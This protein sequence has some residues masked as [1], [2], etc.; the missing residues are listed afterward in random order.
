MDLDGLDYEDICEFGNSEPSFLYHI[1]AMWDSQ[2]L[3]EF[4][5]TQPCVMRAGPASLI[6]DPF[7][8]GKMCDEFNVLMPSG[9]VVELPAL[10]DN[11]EPDYFNCK[12][13]D[14]S[15]RFGPTSEHLSSN[16]KFVLTENISYE[17]LNGGNDGFCGLRLTPEQLGDNQRAVVFHCNDEK[18]TIIMCTP[19]QIEIYDEG[20]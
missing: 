13:G 19:F 17:S 3:E 16:G 9:E 6:L 20:L 1:H 10:N 14:L 18:K 7:V 4:F 11:E 5:G 2:E 12:I 8:T 15:G